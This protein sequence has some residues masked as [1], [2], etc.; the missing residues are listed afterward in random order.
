MLGQRFLK[1][2]LFT[3]PYAKHPWRSRGQR[4][5]QSGRPTEEPLRLPRMHAVT[6]FQMLRWNVKQS[7]HPL[8]TDIVRMLR[9][10]CD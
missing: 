2:L 10:R 9:E 1:T 5:S 3:F 4:G 7:Q 8:S 6:A